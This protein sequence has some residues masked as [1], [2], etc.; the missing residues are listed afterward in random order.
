MLDSYS[1]LISL[2]YLARKDLLQAFHTCLKVLN[3][4]GE[5]LPPNGNVDKAELIS[6]LTQ[7]KAL[8]QK[9]SNK[10]LLAMHEETS[11]RKITIMQFYDQLSIVSYLAK[12]ELCPYFMARWAHF[13]L[14]N[15]VSCKYTPGKTIVAE[16]I[17]CFG[18]F[19][20]ATSQLL[21]WFRGIRCICVIFFNIVL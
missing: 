13:S 2:F 15:N 7:T 18:S 6:I 8:F 11:R 12:P 9:K 10:E 20:L 17:W 16:V 14:T 3:L 4:L 21:F 5:D 1:I 19:W